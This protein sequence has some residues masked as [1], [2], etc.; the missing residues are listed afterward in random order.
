[1]MLLTCTLLE[2]NFYTATYRITV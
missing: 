1:M 2:M